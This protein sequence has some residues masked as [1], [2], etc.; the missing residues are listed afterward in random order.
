MVIITSSLSDTNPEISA[1]TNAVPVHLHLLDIDQ[2]GVY[3]KLELIMSL[4][5]Q[6]AL[7]TGI[8]IKVHKDII[9]LFAMQKY[10][11]NI[12]DLRNEIQIACSKA[13]LNTSVKKKQQHLFNISMFIIEYVK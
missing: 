4:L 12:S 7:D 13:F 11:N 10:P 3:E 8:S 1:I 5:Q 6:E 2:R 9:T